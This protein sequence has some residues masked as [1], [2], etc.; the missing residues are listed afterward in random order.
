MVDHS[1]TNFHNANL[2]TRR[3]RLCEGT[4]NT[5]AAFEKKAHL[6]GK[7]CGGTMVEEPLIH[8]LAVVSNAPSFAYDSER[9]ERDA[10]AAEFEHRTQAFQQKEVLS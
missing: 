7:L 9:F 5:W 8:P 4:A 3:E 2:K 1:G 6:A 10:A